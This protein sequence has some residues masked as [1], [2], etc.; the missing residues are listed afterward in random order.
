[1]N[2]ERGMPVLKIEED[3]L[4]AAWEKAVLATWRSGK[5][6]KTEYDKKEEPPS[7]ETTIII[8]DKK[9]S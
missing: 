2:N 5:N 1:M 8:L 6:I 4:P 7:K 9:P 3:T